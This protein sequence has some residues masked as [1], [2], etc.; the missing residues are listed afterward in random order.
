MPYVIIRQTQS[1]QIFFV[2]EHI[3]NYFSSLAID[4]IAVKVQLL[5]NSLILQ[6]VAKFF[7]QIYVNIAA[8]QAKFLEITHIF[9]CFDHF[10]SIWQA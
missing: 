9:Q 8:V 5:K 1:F 4:V 10:Y 7:Q 3:C 6:T 2:F